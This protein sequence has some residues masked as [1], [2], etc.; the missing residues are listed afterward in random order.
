MGGIEL[1]SIEA[2]AQ[3]PESTDLRAIL[4]NQKN[5]S[6]HE[7]QPDVVVHAC[8]PSIWE[9]EAGQIRNISLA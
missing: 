1:S 5:C 8:H 3:D 9:A 6:K 4:C 2:R 7:K